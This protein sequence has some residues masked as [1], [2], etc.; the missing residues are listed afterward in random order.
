MTTILRSKLHTI[1]VAL[2]AAA[3]LVAGC[4]SL[5]IGGTDPG[6]GPGFITVFLQVPEGMT[7]SVAPDGSFNVV[8]GDDD[9]ELTLT[10]ARLVWDDLEFAR[11]G[12]ECEVSETAEDGDDCSEALIAPSLLNLRIAESP[13]SIALGS[14][15]VEPGTYDRLQFSLHVV[16]AGESAFLTQ[17]FQ[18]GTSVEA[19]GTIVQSGETS[20]V[21][22]LFGP[23]GTVDLEF[24]EEVTVEAGGAADVTI[25]V[26]VADWFRADDGSV[27][28]P[29]DA[30][31]GGQLGADVRENILQSFEVSVGG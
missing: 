18:E 30:D 13:A 10:Q 12:G 1:P 27:I 7:A 17:G 21:S 29:G 9:T 2:A 6:D 31:E 23:T 16:Q 26:N 24:G 15:P 19:V 25:V 22:S 11:T 28:D 5:E 14:T 8:V 20:T 3:L 4:S